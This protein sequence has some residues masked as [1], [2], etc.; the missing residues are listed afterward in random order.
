M[1]N[2]TRF[3]P[4][5]DAFD[6][7]FRGLPVWL[8]NL[9]RREI[10][11]AQFRMDVSENERE[12]QVLAEMPGLKKEDISITINVNEVSVSAEVKQEKDAKNGDTQLRSERYFGKI[13]R[14][15]TLSH[16]V[17]QANAQAK[18][19]DGVLQLTLPKKT[20]AALK[21]LAVH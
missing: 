8:P 10:A 5:D 12:Y 13:Q 20:A 17:D 21:K 2:I 7:M 1:V 14:A 16:E 15:F 11:P 9:E 19:T 18:Y 6:N 4:L 3:N